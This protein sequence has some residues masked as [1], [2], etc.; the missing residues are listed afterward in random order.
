[1]KSPPTG[2]AVGI[3]RNKKKQ[4]HYHDEIDA[5]GSINIK[6]WDPKDVERFSGTDDPVSNFGSSSFLV[7][8]AID[9]VNTGSI[10]VECPPPP[11][12]TFQDY[13]RP[14]PLLAPSSTSNVNLEPKVSLFARN[15]SA[16]KNRSFHSNQFSDNN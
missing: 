2:G 10:I 4:V 16:F 5:R 1:L 7:N 15:N 13:S 8:Q 3:L 12:Q 6:T 9:K 11:Q 14:D